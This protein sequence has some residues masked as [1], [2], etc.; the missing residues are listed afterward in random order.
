MEWVKRAWRGEERCWKVFWVY[1]FLGG[2]IWNIV[3]KSLNSMTTSGLVLGVF[4]GAHIVYIIWQFVSQYRCA[5]NLEWR[6][7]GYITRGLALLMPVL[8]IAGILIGGILKGDQ[9][10]VG[11]R[12]KSCER[13][14]T[15][16]EYRNSQ[17]P[18]NY[19][20]CKQHAT[21][22]KE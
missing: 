14:E 21:P 17:P 20:W 12:L 19:E 1:G 16:L 15:D 22:K 8:V 2:I 5:F 6:A 10:I 3:S 11:A 18:A 7:W 13:M 9:L 4:Y